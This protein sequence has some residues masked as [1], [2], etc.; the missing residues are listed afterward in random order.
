MR[1]QP[2]GGVIVN[3]GSIAAH[4]PSP[5]VAAY[6]A[7]KA[8]IASL[9]KSLAVEWG[10]SV[11]VVCVSPG[12]VWTESADAFYADGG[13]KIAA[14]IP[15]GRFGTPDEIGAACVWVSSDQA[16]YISGAELVIDGG[17]ERPAWLTAKETA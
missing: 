1:A 5:Q 15:A 13:D 4:R 17:G 12:M 7:A 2:T 3:I 11:R 10:P 16:S 9:T 6:A 14:T 8:G